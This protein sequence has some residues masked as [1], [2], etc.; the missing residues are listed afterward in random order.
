MRA[1]RRG[2]AAALATFCTAYLDQV[3][4]FI[5]HR[6]AGD[7]QITEDIVQET[8]LA[9]L[10]ALEHYDGRASLSTWLCGIARHKI[11]DH[12]RRRQR[13]EQARLALEH[14]PDLMAEPT[15]RLERDALRQRVL[16]TLRV[17]PAH[18]QQVLTL[19]Y[20][21]RLSGHRLAEYLGLSEDAAESLLA[22]ARSAFRQGFPQQ[23]VSIWKEHRHGPA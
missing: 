23:D 16:A 21:D 4:S 17:L 22:R 7:R 14:Q 15:E 13:L 12:Y 20:L 8:F 5:Y 6:L 10:E 19:K 18:Y 1:L 9:A 11:A 3:Y 2:D